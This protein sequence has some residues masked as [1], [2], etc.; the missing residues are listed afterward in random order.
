VCW[1]GCIGVSLVV[2]VYVL[3]CVG[4]GVDVYLYVCVHVCAWMSMSARVIESL[5]ME[6]EGG[7]G[8][9]EV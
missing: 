7:R 4:V 1:Y 9:S 8:Y 6:G 5:G 3:V 2:G